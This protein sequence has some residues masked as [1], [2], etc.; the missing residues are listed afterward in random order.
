[1]LNV[2]ST[3]SASGGSGSTTIASAA[4]TPSGT[5]IPER[6]SERKSRAVA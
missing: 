1:M 3:S 6:T 5:P 2:N 4:S